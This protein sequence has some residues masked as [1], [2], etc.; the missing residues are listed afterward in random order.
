MGRTDH[1][2][3]KASELEDQPCSPSLGVA[4]MVDELSLVVKP[5]AGRPSDV[6]HQL[7]ADSQMDIFPEQLADIIAE[8]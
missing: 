5:A 6:W 7:L 1:R 4:L 3:R 8:Q 2:N